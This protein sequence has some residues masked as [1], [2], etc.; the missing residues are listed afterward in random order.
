MSFNAAQLEAL[1]GKI[2]ERLDP[3]DA[4]LFATVLVT[5]VSNLEQPPKPR[6][7]ALTYP[8]QAAI[9]RVLKVAEKR[10]QLAG[11]RV[12][13]GGAITVWDKSQAPLVTD[14]IEAWRASRQT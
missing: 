4:K 11:F 6:K 14:E 10:G 9:D 5:I 7:P 13:P 12:E 2:A 3:E 1:G 8:S